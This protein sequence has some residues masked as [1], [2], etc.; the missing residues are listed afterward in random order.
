MTNSYVD[1]RRI[2]SVSTKYLIIPDKAC[3]GVSTFLGKSSYTKGEVGWFSD[4]N[5]NQNSWRV[6]EA[7]HVKIICFCQNEKLMFVIR[8]NFLRLLQ[9]KIL[10]YY[11]RI[12]ADLSIFFPALLHVWLGISSHPTCK[13]I[14]FGNNEWFFIIVSYIL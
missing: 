8:W 3:R 12:L 6:L 13:I 2:K 9:V 11:E 14:G 10:N 4:W 7:F 1:N 5:S